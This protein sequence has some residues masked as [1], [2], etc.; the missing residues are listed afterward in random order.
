MRQHNM[1]CEM[2]NMKQIW[3]KKTFISLKPASDTNDKYPVWVAMCAQYLWVQERTSF[4]IFVQPIPKYS[5]QQHVYPNQSNPKIPLIK[6]AFHFSSDLSLKPSKWRIIKKVRFLENWIHLK[7]KNWNCFA[8][9]AWEGNPKS[10]V[11]NNC[12]WHKRNKNHFSL[13]SSVSNSNFWPT[14]KQIV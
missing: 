2:W 14:M 10:C 11:R 12:F 4:G 5:V 8:S 1:K 3:L 7:S 13:Y 6:D 9:S